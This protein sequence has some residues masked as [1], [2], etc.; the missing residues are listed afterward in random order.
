[1]GR[2]V[3]GL[4]PVAAVAAIA[5]GAG[6]LLYAVWR[7]PHRND[8]IAYWGLVATVVTIAT[9]WMSWAWR[10]RAR[11]SAGAGDQAA[12]DQLAD[13]L[14][15]AVAS[16][17]TRAAADRGLLVPEPIPVRWRRPSVPLAGPSAAAAAARRF[18][19]LPG[20]T[21]VTAAQLAK[22]NISDLH[23][24]YA[25]LGSGRLVIAGAP[26]SGKSGAAVLL[27]LAALAHREQV[28]ETD[29]PRVPVPVMFT[30]HGWD[31]LARPVQDWLGLRLGQTYPVLAGPD[32][33]A[34]SAR[35]LAEGKLAVILD[36]L[37]EIP[38]DLQPAAL[39]ALSQQATFR[40]VVLSR[41]GEMAAAAAQGHLDG[42]A[43]VELQEVD[44]A[45]AAGYLTRV[46]LDP[47]PAGW[48]EL[49]ARLR[50]APGSPLAQALGSPLTLGLLRD[51]YRG[52]DD[53]RELLGFSGSPASAEA[54]DEI[55][56]HLLDRVLP[57]AY[58]PQ[59]GKP[60]PR[61]DR[62]K[63]QRALSQLAARMNRDGT[64]DLRWWN[65]PR[66][67]TAWPRILVAV[68]AVAVLALPFAGSVPVA[69]VVLGG[70]YNFQN[71][72]GA[73]IH[74]G[75]I[76]GSVAGLVFWFGVTRRHRLP[77]QIRLRRWHQ[78]LRRDALKRGLAPGLIVG[79]GTGFVAWLLATLVLAPQVPRAL[80]AEAAL[81]AGA[82][83]G[84]ATALVFMLSGP[85]ADDASSIVPASSWR[86]DLAFGLVIGLVVGLVLG[87]ASGLAYASLA[88]ASNPSGVFIPIVVGNAPGG[89]TSV[90][91]SMPP[92][93]SPLEAGLGAGLGTG[94]AA[95]LGFMLFSTRTWP[96]TLAFMQLAIRWHT[97]PRLMRFLEDARQ[98]NVLRIIGP[99]YQFRHARL[100]DRLAG[101]A[102]RPASQP[103]PL[104]LQ[105][106]NAP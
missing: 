61:Y 8:L 95:A 41:T 83:A 19:P 84:L 17:W 20:M 96:A 24:L 49:T 30:L 21:L 54:R 62:Q 50:R 5:A 70:D 92:G 85:G 69:L 15:R 39:R 67:V 60:P 38:A 87:I 26:G 88:A 34:Q 18:E 36:G 31:P 100:Q 65:I 44:A 40:L 59:P 71:T 104:V 4:W 57:A 12:I 48:K 81:A 93:P 82:A 73:G 58:A 64:R 51:T 11:A 2:K 53:A 14:A 3:R 74:N 56:D 75:L 9:G 29:R 102:Y 72:F 47:P 91:V 78:A 33:A 32:G 43:A 94:L 63:A 99:V 106:R 42:A 66:W 46:Q 97:P 28:P 22:G 101:Q 10:T 16:Q 6:V 86:N 68:L 25:G 105:G 77:R 35:L 80:A 98:R 23:R 1:M 37:D 90:V 76:C 79:I 13:V 89:P 103:D 55:I 52:P 45:T 7:S 27:I